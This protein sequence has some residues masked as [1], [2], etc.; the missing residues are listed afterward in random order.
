MM[1]VKKGKNGMIIF[2]KK[3]NSHY[4]VI[5]TPKYHCIKEKPFIS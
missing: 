5:P 3:K 4:N 1:L 2:K